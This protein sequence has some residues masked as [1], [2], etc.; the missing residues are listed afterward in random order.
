MMIFIP[1]M[2]QAVKAKMIQI[3]W[4]RISLSLSFFCLFAMSCADTV[5]YFTTRTVYLSMGT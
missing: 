4:V 1:K 5:Y 2:G 3:A